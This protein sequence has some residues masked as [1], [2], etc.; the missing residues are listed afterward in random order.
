MPAKYT[1]DFCGKDLEIGY[2]NQGIGKWQF[3]IT[4]QTMVERHFAVEIRTISNFN[5]TG[6]CWC[7]DC[8]KAGLKSVL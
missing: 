5:T 3:S 2:T 8:L 4:D 6:I 7:K 1:C